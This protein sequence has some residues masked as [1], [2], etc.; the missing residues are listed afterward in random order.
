MSGLAFSVAPSKQV[1]IVIRMSINTTYNILKCNIFE[2]FGYLYPYIFSCNIIIVHHVV[3]INLTTF[4]GIINK[5]ANSANLRYGLQMVC[6]NKMY[7]N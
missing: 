6:H 7:N 3:F 1:N 2:L 5:Y 4:P